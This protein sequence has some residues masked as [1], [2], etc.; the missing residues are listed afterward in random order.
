MTLVSLL[1]TLTCVPGIEFFEPMDIWIAEGV[2]AYETTVGNGQVIESGRGAKLE[3]ELFDGLGRLL[4]S[5]GQRGQQFTYVPGAGD[6]L[7][8]AALSGMQEGGE[9]V[10]IFS[11]DRF[12]S[13][14]G[15][16]VPPQTELTLR[17]RA[18]R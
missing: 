16:L 5:S 6:P 14:L 13:G 2:A 12:P 15:S 17:L 18:T 11:P 3:F 9:R 4:Q 8:D 7:L 10:V 1:A